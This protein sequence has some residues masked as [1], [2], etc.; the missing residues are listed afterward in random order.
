MVGLIVGFVDGSEVGADNL[1][2]ESEMSSM[3]RTNLMMVGVLTAM[4]LSDSLMA[5]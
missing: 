5:F 4:E 1:H 2:E 3:F